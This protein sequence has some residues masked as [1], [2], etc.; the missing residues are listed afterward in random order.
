MTLK[1]WLILFDIRSL[2]KATVSKSFYLKKYPVLGPCPFP[3]WAERRRDRE[4][5][6]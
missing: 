3:P 1:G 2:F 4:R 6:C 5:L